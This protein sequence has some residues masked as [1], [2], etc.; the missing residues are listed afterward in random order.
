[1]LGLGLRYGLGYWLDPNQY[2]KPYPN[3]NPN[4]YN[5]PY[6]NPNPNQYNKRYPNPNPSTGLYPS[7]VV[8]Q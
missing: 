1:M 4:Q 5:K 2:N 7:K 6:P 8:S 3:P